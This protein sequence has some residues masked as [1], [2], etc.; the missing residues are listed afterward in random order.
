MKQVQVY[1]SLDA[2]STAKD[3]T[4][5]L[6]FRT[7][8]MDPVEAGVLHALVHNEGYV[9]FAPDAIQEMKVPEG[10]PEFKDGKSPSQRLR[11]VIYVYWEQQ[12]KQGDFETFR[13]QKM[14]TLIDFIKSKLE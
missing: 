11:N 12:G 7:Q 10:K 4:L 8:E 5:K 9:A 6:V 2:I 3:R 14:E 1:G 13:K